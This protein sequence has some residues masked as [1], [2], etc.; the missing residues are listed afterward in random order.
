MRKFIAAAMSAVMLLSAFPITAQAANENSSDA[1]TAFYVS[2]DG[3]DSNSGTESEPFK[4]IEKARDEVRKHTKDMTSD[5]VVYLKDGVY[6]QDETL[7]FGTEDSG[8]NGYQVRYEAYE[9]AAPEISGG[10]LLEGTWEVDDAEKNIY[11]ISVPEG[12]NFRQLY[13]NGKKGIRARTGVPTGE[14]DP[15]SRIL[16]AERF[17]S[18]GKN[19]GYVYVPADERILEDPSEMGGENPV[20]LHIFAAWT[21]NILRVGEM[22]YVDNY[23]GEQAYKV[24]VQEP[25]SERVFSRPHP[26]LT[27]YVG[28]KKFAFYYENAYEYIDLDKE[29]YLD[30]EANTL[31]YKA[32]AGTTAEDMNKASVVVPNLEKVVSIKGESLDAPIHD[33]VFKGITVEHSTW[34][35]ASEEGLVQGQAGQYLVDGSV[36]ETNDIKVTPSPGA[37]HIENAQ[38][39]R[40]DG[41]HV[42][43]TGAVGILMA[44]GTKE[45]TLVN[46]EVEE[47]AG[48]GIEIGKF[49]VDDKTDYHTAYN[50]DDIREVCTN[51]RILNNKIHDIG[52]QYEGSVGIGAGYVQGIM[53]ANNTVYNCPYTGISMGYGWTN[54]PNPMKY[55]SIIRNEVYNV[56]NV[57][58][59]GG[60]IYTLSNQY[61]SSRIEENYLH[62]NYASEGL[63]YGSCGIYLD[64]QSDGFSVKNNV[65][66]QSYGRVNLNRV[67]SRNDI[68]GNYFF[69]GDV[70][71]DAYDSFA[72]TK[73]QQI[74]DQAGAKDDFTLEDEE[75]LFRPVLQSVE[76]DPVYNVMRLSGRNFGSDIGT[77]TFNISGEEKVIAAEQV[78]EWSYGAISVEVPE[79]AKR[80]DTVTVTPK[81][82]SVASEP[83]TIGRIMNVVTELVK[84]D[85]ED[86]DAGQLDSNEWEV[87]VPEKAAVAEKDGN[88]YLSL[89]GN[90][91]NLNVTKLQD[92][93]T[94]QFGSNVT[95]FDF[96]FPEDM[97]GSV[98]YVGLYNEIRRLPGKDHL[99]SIDIRPVFG[100]KATIEYKQGWDG[101][102]TND[103]SLQEIKW[104]TWYTCRSMVYNGTIY[105][106]VFEKGQDPNGWKVT[107]EMPDAV[108]N[109]CVLNFSF[110]DPRGKEVYI[111][112]IKVSTFDADISQPEVDEADYDINSGI[113][114][115]KGYGFTETKGTVTYQTEN[116]PAELSGDAISVWT[117]ELIQFTRPEDGISGTA[118]ATTSEGEK[119]EEFFLKLPVRM[120]SYEENFDTLTQEQ[121]GYQ[122]SVSNKNGD[123]MPEDS[124]VIFDD[125]GNKVLK[126]KGSDP[127]LWVDLLNNDLQASK[128]G[129]NI[130]TFDFKFPNGIAG[131]YGMYN[132]L[133][134][135]EDGTV[136]RLGI[137][138]TDGSHCFLGIKDG[139]TSGSGKD[140]A[141]N[142]W[143][144][145][146]TM[147]Y[148]DDMYLKVWKTG[149]QEPENW[150]VSFQMA[151]FTGAEECQ[152]NF[153]YYDPSGSYPLYIDNIKV[154]V[155][156]ENDVEA[157]LTGIEVAEGPDK[158]VYYI[159]EDF[160]ADGLKINAVFND[161]SKQELA[162]DAYALSGFDSE[163]EGSKTVT[164]S[165]RGFTDDFTVQVQKKPVITEIKITQQPYKTVYDLGEELDVTGLTVKAV[166]DNG[167]EETVS[168][169]DCTVTGFDSETEGVKTV[170]VSY[171]GKTAQFTVEVKAQEVPEKTLTG[172]RIDQKPTKTEYE[173][174]EELDL[175]GL[176]VTGIYDDQ[177]EAVL[178]E[179]AYSV[180]GFDSET[181]GVKTV[182]VSCQGKTAQFEIQ[183]KASASSGSQQENG[184]EGQSPQT[185]DNSMPILWVLCSMVSLCLIVIGQKRYKKFHS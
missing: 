93:E 43:Y 103:S 11:K 139:N 106:S 165:Y 102:Q 68:S 9:G 169:S 107:Y 167:T 97:G 177:S 57:V 32:P 1:E 37:V 61:P 185:G 12:M 133:R 29:W 6:Y 54:V 120:L 114:T 3:S 115:I 144:T 164:V 155:L 100:S 98:D 34:L 149:E 131:Y 85:F 180:A 137:T 175:S 163:T 13:V 117:N 65:H 73:V 74:M 156:D 26:D 78:K 28:V 158:D 174:G 105:L 118:F 71:S 159:G 101:I 166:Y 113:V 14:L 19:S 152:L 83:F 80:G 143:Y 95:E 161:G 5:I 90:D 145:C 142:T 4:T 66:V 42:R 92:G 110:Y 33:F 109:D 182:T 69:E 18:Q 172:I 151:D 63:D 99:Y 176:V 44:S 58:C 7:A 70:N 76:Y 75:E 128:Y 168:L 173:V 87:T 50:P 184:A 140:V 72:T 123:T 112:N 31:Y 38:Y 15:T 21:E 178:P 104:G 45:V 171:Q 51:D 130:T 59:D 111:D 55:N 52:T 20:E 79:G 94:L 129:E 10:K 141:A 48:N 183:V 88:Q 150:D 127:D 148:D 126:L 39:V 147:V 82:M 136:Y 2:P 23:N 122:Y 89:K 153:A 135:A 64:E 30:T 60:A 116:G 119:S 81:G 134:R 157:R 53:I 49:V 125:N 16:G 8:T 138:P 154:E 17:T 25:E 162:Q 96:C 108:S 27:G 46:N 62:D 84:E 91:P 40:F 56:N 41:N 22:E 124:A 86:K 146:K 170:M 36:Y 24:T 47:T 179:G 77:I 67:G 160:T 35:Q 181:E 132:E 121:F